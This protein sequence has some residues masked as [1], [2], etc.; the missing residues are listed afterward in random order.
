MRAGNLVELAEAE[1]LLRHPTQQYTKDLLS[2]VP[3]IVA[4]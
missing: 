2:A 1:Q 3:E 4:R